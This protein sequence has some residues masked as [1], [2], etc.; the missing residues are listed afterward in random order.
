MFRVEQ[1]NKQVFQSTM[2]F[3]K[4]GIIGE[5]QSFLWHMKGNV[6]KPDDKK[7][8]VPI[9]IKPNKHQILLDEYEIPATELDLRQLARV[10]IDFGFSWSRANSTTNTQVSQTTHLKV[11]DA[12]LRLRFLERL[13]SNQ[14]ALTEAGKR[15]L[16]HF[17]SE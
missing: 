13:N 15:F 5:L 6:Y 17:A 1:S 12:F 11:Q 7:I 9:T 8:I 3:F 4:K 2:P 16:R 14:Y 10:Y